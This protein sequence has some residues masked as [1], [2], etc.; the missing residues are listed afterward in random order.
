LNR[1][2]N[3]YEK[4]FKNVAKGGKLVTYRHIE[5]EILDERNFAYF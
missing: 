3:F 4:I 5:V 2:L 1:W